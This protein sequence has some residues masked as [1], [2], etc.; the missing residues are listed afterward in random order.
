MTLIQTINTFADIGNVAAI[1]TNQWILQSTL[2]N[3]NTKNTIIAMIDIQ[4]Q[5]IG[6]NMVGP[7]ENDSIYTTTDIREVVVNSLSLTGAYDAEYCV[8]FLLF[9]CYQVC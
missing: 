1:E 4:N 2:I 5:N 7:I 9:V 3:T 6:N 8:I